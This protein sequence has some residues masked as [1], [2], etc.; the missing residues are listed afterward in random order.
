MNVLK[1]VLITAARNEAQYIEKT[2]LSVVSQTI[3]PQKWVIVAN[4]CTD[5]TEEIVCAYADEYR[6]IGLIRLPDHDRASFAAK[7][8]CFNR[9]VQCLR[10]AEY[11]YIG[12]VDADVSFEPD[13]FEYLLR[14]FV[15]EPQLGVAGTPYLE[16][17]THS[18]RG[19][20]VS[21]LH[22]HG[23][24]QLFRRACFE[25]IGGYVPVCCGGV[26]WIA[27]STARMT[28]WKTYSFQDKH[29]VH[30]R[31]MGTG[32][33]RTL[34]G[35]YFRRG[36]QEYCVGNHPL[37][38][39]ARVLYQCTSRPYLLKGVMILIG[40]LYG[41]VTAMRRPVSKPLIRFHR[42]EQLDRLWIMLRRFF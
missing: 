30:L 5:R 14:Q 1:Y 31:A 24:I 2:I 34:I 13:Y 22:V 33:S 3:L 37:W 7:A 16:G 25:T 41:Y 42:K 12:N 29:F 17:D 10:D 35:T 32:V 23:Q 9:G 40:Y 8:V 26:D 21:I 6:W 20:H 18:Y 39:V 4:G 28:G 19:S 38:Q 15:N 36:V 11:G 27:V